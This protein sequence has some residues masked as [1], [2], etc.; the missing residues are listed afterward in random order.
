[1]GNFEGILET[2]RGQ[3]VVDIPFPYAWEEALH[4]G[5]VRE[6]GGIHGDA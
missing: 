6:E 1:M 4:L 2:V 5:S 3:V